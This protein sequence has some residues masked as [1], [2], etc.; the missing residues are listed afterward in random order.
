MG[1]AGCFPGVRRV[2]DLGVGV[3]SRARISSAGF[4]SLSPHSLMSIFP[5]VRIFPPS[6]FNL[7]SIQWPNAYVFKFTLNKHIHHSFNIII[8][9]FIS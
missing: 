3:C 6:A 7:P 5:L 1:E 8:L 2:A 4:H 9:D